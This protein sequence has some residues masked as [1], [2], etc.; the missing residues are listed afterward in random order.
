MALSS[1]CGNEYSVIYYKA[2]TRTTWLYLLKC[3]AQPT[4]L[5]K[6]LLKWKCLRF[7]QILII[8]IEHYE[9]DNVHW[10]QLWKFR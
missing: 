9:N 2:Y 6:H 7:D 4:V 10:G 5:K 8:C 3:E 1:W